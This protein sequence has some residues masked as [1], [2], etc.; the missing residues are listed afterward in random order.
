MKR[1]ILVASIAFALLSGWTGGDSPKNV[2]CCH[3]CDRYHCKKANCGDT[4]KQGPN[5]RGCWTDCKG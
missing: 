1:W 4:C 3:G 5:C 2:K